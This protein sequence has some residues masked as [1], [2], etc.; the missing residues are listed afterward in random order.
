MFVIR[1]SVRTNLHTDLHI[2]IIPRIKYNTIISNI[3][4]YN[5]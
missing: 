4:A 2:N 1:K 3:I 5:V